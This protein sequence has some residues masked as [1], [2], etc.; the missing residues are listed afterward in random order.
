MQYLKQQYKEIW[1][2]LCRELK[3]ILPG[4]VVFFIAVIVLTHLFMVKNP[5]MQ[6]QFMEM[7][8]NS[9]PEGLEEKTGLPMAAD[10][11][12]NNTIACIIA[13]VSG[14]VPFL[15]LPVITLFV[16]AAVLGVLGG[17]YQNMG[18]S[19]AGM[20]VFGIMPHGIFELP[21]ILLSLAM[22]IRLCYCLVRRICEGRYNRGIV[23][24]TLTGALRTFM[25]V[26]IPLLIIAALIESQLTPIL[27]M[28]FMGL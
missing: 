23:K 26:I 22:G 14:F 3:W 8:H 11:F 28:K 17:V 16:N 12:R 5:D 6:A 19:V 21:A 1:R 2:Y 18:M 20:Y 15:F 10:L 25:L 27:L 9:L 24:E 7:I 13:V 4:V